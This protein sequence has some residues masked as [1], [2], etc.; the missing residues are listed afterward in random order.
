MSSRIF[1]GSL[2]GGKSVP[3]D[4]AVKLSL[5]DIIKDEIPGSSDSYRNYFEISLSSDD[6]ASAFA[7]E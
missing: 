4:L 5:L 2:L 3:Y 7:Q 6:P 1:K